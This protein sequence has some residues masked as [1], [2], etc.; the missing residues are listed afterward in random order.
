MSG[1][2]AYWVYIRASRPGGAIYIGVTNDL[3]K[4]VGE[5]RAGTGSQH[6][7]RYGIGTLV[8]CEEF[9]D[10]RE[11]IQRETSLKRWPRKWK[12]D[13]IYKTN[14]TWADLLAPPNVMTGLETVISI[15]KSE[16]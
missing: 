3:E 14:P 16:R 2:K 13:L 10:V 8:W 6:C 5:H 15:V 1:P 12:T 11:A 9:Q 4:R 7:R